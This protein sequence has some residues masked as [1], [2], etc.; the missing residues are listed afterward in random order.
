MNIYLRKIIKN[1]LSMKNEEGNL[2]KK[3]LFIKIV[4][5]E[6]IKKMYVREF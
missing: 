1:F 3:E 2:C 6:T 4:L 5:R